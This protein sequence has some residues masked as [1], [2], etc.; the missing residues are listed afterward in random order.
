MN[1]TDRKQLQKI[2]KVFEKQIKTL[3]VNDVKMSLHA[4]YKTKKMKIVYGIFID[5]GLNLKG[6]RK[7][8]KKT[9][10]L[11]LKNVG[12]YE[13]DVLAVNLP[14]FIERIRNDVNNS[15]KSVGFGKDKISYWHQLFVS[16]PMRDGMVKLSKAT[17]TGGN[18]ALTYLTDYLEKHEPKMLNIWEWSNDGR[19]C[20]TR[21]LRYKQSANQETKNKKVWT[22]GTTK[23]MYNHIRS[24]FNWLPEQLDGY[25][26]NLVNGIRTTP[27]KPITTSFTN[28]EIQ[29]VKDFIQEK[30]DDKTWGWFVKMLCVMLETGTR[31]T[32][33]CTMKIEDVSP[34]DATWTF[35][36]KGRHGGKER[37]CS[38]P[39][40]VWQMIEDLIVDENGFKRADKEF[41]FH[42]KFF[43]VQDK[44]KYPNSWVETEDLST[45]ISDEGFRK[46]FKKM[47]KEL[48]INPIMT[49]HSCRRYF[50]TEMLKK[51]NGNIPLVAEL[52]GH[53]DWAQVKR[54]TKSVL[55]DKGST[56]V[57]LFD[58][59][60]VS[61][62]IMITKKMKLKLGEMGY[63]D[64]KI[65][66]LKPEQ[67]HEIIQ[68]GF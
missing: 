23:T 18:R 7:I 63:T 29:S 59:N 41:V 46:R 39:H 6:E 14:K 13:D 31:I 42:P 2:R 37:S 30:R 44:V 67:A 12:L 9:K 54:Y 26:R 62:P 68:R 3:K 19:K 21:F 5:A 32:E 16:E 55:L 64:G 35:L 60:K 11:Y 10:Y 65:K 58:E 61:I 47:V 36:G 20:L 17:L 49:P 34:Q 22:D 56:N 33:V 43:K 57:G 25:P 51:T 15:I 1:K 50:I 24:F 66:I 27:Y 40:Y 45:H 8:K 52:V 38:I 48:N 53:S 28:Y 4:D